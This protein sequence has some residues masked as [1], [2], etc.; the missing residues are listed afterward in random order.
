MLSPRETTFS[1]TSAFVEDCLNHIF[2]NY[3][4]LFYSNLLRYLESGQVKPPHL[5]P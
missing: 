5:K 2:V 1:E 4:R 3:L